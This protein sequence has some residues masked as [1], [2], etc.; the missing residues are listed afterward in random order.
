MHLRRGKDCAA[1]DCRHFRKPGTPDTV[2]IGTWI[3]IL[4]ASFS[5]LALTVAGTVKFFQWLF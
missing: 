2:L 3:G 5:I 4:L 1:C